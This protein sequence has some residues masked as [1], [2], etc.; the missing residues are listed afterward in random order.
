MNGFT[1]GLNEHLPFIHAPSLSIAECKPALVLAVAA[2][3]SQY[4][5]ETHR[6][7]ELFNA[8]KVLLLDDLRYQRRFKLPAP[9][10][11]SPPSPSCIGP[12]RGPSRYDGVDADPVVTQYLRHVRQG[13]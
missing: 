9:K 6:G 7:V 11:I 8:A 4:R 13:R 5:F 1:D 3:G 2:C 10:P 12:R